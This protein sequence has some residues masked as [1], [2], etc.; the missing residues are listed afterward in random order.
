MQLSLASSKTRAHFRY[1]L[2]SSELHTSP[3]CRSQYHTLRRALA[4][5][6][7]GAG[8]GGQRPAASFRG[9]GNGRRAH[10]AGEACAQGPGCVSLGASQHPGR[11]CGVPDKREAEETE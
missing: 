10:R 3:I 9:L 11:A 2:P 7:R 1:G 6:S 4:G 8:T 5:D